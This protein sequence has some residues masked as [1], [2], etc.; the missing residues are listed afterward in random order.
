ML[1]DKPNRVHHSKTIA[2]WN[3]FVEEKSVIL[4]TVLV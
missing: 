4:F 1:V 3:V 2:T